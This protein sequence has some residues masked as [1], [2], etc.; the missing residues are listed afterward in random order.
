MSFR[1][2]DKDADDMSFYNTQNAIEQRLFA[3]FAKFRRQF[4]E[5]P[6]NGRVNRYEDV[7]AIDHRRTLR[8]SIKDV[9]RR[10][11]VE[12]N[13]EYQKLACAYYRISYGELPTL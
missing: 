11:C 5:T 10:V 4:F 12:P 3:V 13:E 1:I 2:S 7:T 6:L 9:F 8:S